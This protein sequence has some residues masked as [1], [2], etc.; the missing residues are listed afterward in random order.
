MLLEEFH[1]SA[2]GGHSGFFRTYK[3]ISAIIYWEGMRKDIQQ[4]VATCEVCQ[5]NKYQTLSPAGL[6]QPLPIPTQVWA[7]ISMDFIEGLPKAQGKNVILVVVDRL[8]KYAHF[9]PLSHPFTAKDVAESFIKEVVKL[10][11][12]PSTIVS[13]R[14]KIFLS[15]FWSELF[16]MAGT[17]LKFSSAYHPQTDGQT[18]VVNRCLET[19]LRCLTGTKPKQW[20]T[21]LGW[22]EFWFNTNYNSSL[23]LTPFKALYGRDPPHLLRG[24]II[25]SAV[26]EV[27]QLTQERDQILHDLKDNLTK[28]QVQMKAYADR[29]R[30]AVTLFVGD[31]VYLKHQP[32][33]LKSLAKKRNEKLSPRFYGPYQIKKQIGLVAFELDLPPASKIHPVFH[34]SLL[35]KA[36]AATA[37]PQPLPPMLS[38]DLE[39]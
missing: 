23:K 7:D 34:A 8:T 13:D 12:F 3:R 15:N 28:A 32:Y 1:N 24:T 17:K 25:P 26:E 18:E 21:W 31:W 38:E 9:I 11:G 20:T 37:N 27:N 6:L 5:I 2:I 30:R 4:Y 29:S 10:H 36:V 39:L 33:R 35:K 14:D 19:Y 22:A 16:K